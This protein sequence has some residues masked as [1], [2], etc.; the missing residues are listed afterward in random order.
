M[1]YHFI[2]AE[3]NELRMKFEKGKIVEATL[4]YKD[5]N[6]MRTG[7]KELKK[8]GLYKPDSVAEAL[9]NLFD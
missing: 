9:L 3:E 4:F 8:R 1:D 7:I 2:K 5:G 6:G